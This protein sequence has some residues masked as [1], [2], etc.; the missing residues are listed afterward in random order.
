MAMQ[1][2]ILSQ[3][4]AGM[5]PFHY[6][7]E[8]E[9]QSI[10]VNFRMA[11]VGFDQAIENLGVVSD[12]V[13]YTVA[14]I[15]A[16]SIIQLMS[17]AQPRVPYYA[18]GELGPPSTGQLR[19]SGR[20]V[21]ILSTGAL[22][23]STIIGRGRVDGTVE[24]D[25]SKVKP[26]KFKGSKCRFVRGNITYSRLN[27]S[28]LDIAVWTHESLLAHEERKGKGGQPAAR[29]PGTGPKYL[30]IPWL[31]QKDAIINNIRDSVKS[32]P[33]AVRKGTKIIRRAR[34]KYEV[35][36]IKLVYETIAN[37]GGY[38]GR[39]IMVERPLKGLVT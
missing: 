34:N 37:E 26:S 7:G 11:G 19:E 31:Q 24:A 5:W 23:Y 1:M 36:N 38:F 3:P 35:D 20:A 29:T 2:K 18:G 33:A 16:A 6:G 12:A 25:M 27:S 17:L 30:E 28:G 15:I 8:Q 9:V 32:L 13:S 4:Y 14:N 10:G 39:N 22:P 21:L